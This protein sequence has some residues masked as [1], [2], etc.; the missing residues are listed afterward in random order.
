MEKNPPEIANALSNL[1]TSLVYI[2]NFSFIVNV[3]TANIVFVVRL[4]TL[5]GNCMDLTF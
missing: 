2:L 5:M 4:F 1:P 3:K